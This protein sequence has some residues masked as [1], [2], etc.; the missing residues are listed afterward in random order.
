ML[1]K[2]AP[3]QGSILG[4]NL[5]LDANPE[6]TTPSSEEIEFTKHYQHNGGYDITAY[7]VQGIRIAG[8]DIA[9][10]H[11]KAS[12]TNTNSVVIS[13]IADTRTLVHEMG[14]V[15]GLDHPND[16]TGWP[17]D[18]NGVPPHIH[19]IQGNTDQ[20]TRQLIERNFMTQ[21]GYATGE[22]DYI[23]D[24]QILTILRNIPLDTFSSS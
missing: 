21:S 10:K 17:H 15:L 19:G 14:H 16:E 3:E 24:L 20:T 9:G 4:N 6:K 1:P 5:I 13:D 22:D 2:T 12:F 11:Y 7:F 8:I 23:S 18:Q